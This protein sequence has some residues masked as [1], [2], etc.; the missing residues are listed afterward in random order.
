MTAVTAPATSYIVFLDCGDTIIDEGTEIRD[1]DGVVIAGELLPGADAMVEGLV[2]RGYRVALVADGMAQSF[3]NLLTLHGLYDAFES[4]TYSECV[5]AEKPSPRMFRAALGSLELTESDAPRIVM[6]GNNLAK[7][8]RGAR[9]MGMISVHLAGSPRYKAEPDG[10]EERP[11][12]TIA[13]P[14]QLLPLLDRL[15]RFQAA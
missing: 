6:V 10:A 4:V 12:Y 9:A 3:K 14:D 13:S 11:D 7:D 5:K 2:E 1:D 15:E 8:V